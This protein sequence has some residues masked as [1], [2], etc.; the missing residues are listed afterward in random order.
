MIPVRCT[1]EKP[2][3]SWV[4]EM[5][6]IMNKDLRSE[7]RTKYAINAIV[8]FAVITLAAISFTVGAFALAPQFQAALLWIVLFFSASSGLPRVFIKEEESKTVNAL[9]LSSSPLGVFL[10]KL[11]FNLILLLILASIIV[12]LFIALMGVNIKGL[13]LFVLIVVLG[14]LGLSGASTI[15]A[16]IVAKAATKGTLFAVLAFPILLP[17]LITTISATDYAMGGGTI[18]GGFSHIQ[19]LV[20]YIGIMLTISILLFEFVWQ[21]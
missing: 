11:M 14:L 16:A 20:S 12:P 17:L 18:T 21:E 10:G 7:L 3:Y 6:A 13:A 9:K 15:V 4:R 8:M 1:M 19:I 5:L 2:S